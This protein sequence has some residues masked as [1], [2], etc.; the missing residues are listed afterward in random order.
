MK[1][2]THHRIKIKIKL[3]RYRPGQHLGVLEV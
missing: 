3:S 2:K 1:F